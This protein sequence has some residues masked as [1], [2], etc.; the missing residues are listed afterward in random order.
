MLLK[1]TYIEESMRPEKDTAWYICEFS[2]SFSQE[3]SFGKLGNENQ[4]ASDL[5][6]VSVL[7]NNFSAHLDHYANY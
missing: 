4:Q 5:E 6:L 3:F 7:N 2:G 1:I